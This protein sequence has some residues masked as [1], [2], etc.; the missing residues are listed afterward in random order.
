MRIVTILI[1][2]FLGIQSEIESYKI[3]GIFYT[4]SR[5]HTI[6]GEALMNGLAAAG[7]DITMITAFPQKNPPANLKEIHNKDVFD[8]SIG[9]ALNKISVTK[10]IVFIKNILIILNSSKSF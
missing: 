7:H 6:L 2:F 4:M 8:G 10:L 5:S 9:I 3:L 1:I